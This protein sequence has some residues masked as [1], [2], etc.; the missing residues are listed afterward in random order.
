MVHLQQL[1]DVLGRE[2]PELLSVMGSLHDHLVRPVIG[3]FP[4]ER[5]PGELRRPPLLHRWEL[6]REPAHAPLHRRP[7]SADLLGG[8]GLAARAEIAHARRLLLD[9]LPE[10][11]G[12]LPPR[13]SV[14]DIALEDVVFPDDAHETSLFWQYLMFLWCQLE[15]VNVR[16]RRTPCHASGG[17]GL[18]SHCRSE[19]CG[20]LL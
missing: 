4:E 16:H 9:D 11:L 8:Q 12:A 20:S 5:R 13:S 15:A 14:E 1:R 10:F 19:I 18:A 2:A 3:G 17:A 7:L 6:V